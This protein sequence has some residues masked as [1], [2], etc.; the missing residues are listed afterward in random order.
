MKEEIINGFYMRSDLDIIAD[1][2]EGMACQFIDNG[3]NST[4]LKMRTIVDRLRKI[5][6][7]ELREANENAESSNNIDNR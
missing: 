6:A 2:L 5:S 3:D 4:A 1:Q 7:D